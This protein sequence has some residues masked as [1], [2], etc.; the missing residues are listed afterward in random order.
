M[1]S[2][3]ADG[4]NCLH[5]NLASYAMPATP[6]LPA[7]E[8]RRTETPTPL[9]PLEVKGIGESGTIGATRRSRT[10]SWTPWPIWA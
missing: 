3:T 4:G 2:S 5:G 6:D 1:G 10:R 8:T 9:N 7:F